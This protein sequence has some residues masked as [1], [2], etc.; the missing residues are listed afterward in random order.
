MSAT[1]TEQPQ[2]ETTT[3]AAWQS[4]V[5]FEGVS[6]GDGRFIVADAL[7]WRDPPLTLMAMVETPDFGGHAGAQV[8]GRMD[9]F[10]KTP[11]MIDG[12]KLPKGVLSVLSSGVFDGGEFGADIERMVREQILTG[13]SIDMAIHEWAFRDPDSGEIIDPETADEETWERAFMGELEMAITNGEIMAATVVPTPA[14][15][16]AKIAL[17]AS[18]R[19]FGHAWR[20]NE[21]AAEM[22]GIPEGTLCSTFHANIQIRPSPTPLVDLPDFLVAAASVPVKPPREWFFS[23]EA[24]RATPLTITKDGRVFGHIATWQSCHTG[25]INGAWSQ[26]V[27]PPRSHTEYAH[28]HVG[29]IPTAEGDLI[30]IGKLMIGESHAPGTVGRVAARAHYDRTG[31]VGAFVRALD[32]VHG[33]WVS[34]ALRSGLTDEQMRDLHANPPSG[35]WR[36]VDRNLELIAAIAV[37]V[38]G[39][40]IPRSQLALS[41]SADGEMYVSA[42]I[43]SGG[44]DDVG[45]GAEADVLAAEIDGGPEALHALIEG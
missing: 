29:E 18:T 44:V 16:D 37:P 42:L 23:R 25:F 10:T 22:Y 13:V 20:A 31:T 27:T 8:A 5:A 2:E 6:T 41:A 12:T 32:G 36:D 9:E 28:F 26:C 1:E 15:A 14:F 21:T 40:P 4:D 43:L 45:F 34:G 19:S 35:D 24:D 11:K 39:F 38:P 33:I 17:M 7:G 30:P 3:G